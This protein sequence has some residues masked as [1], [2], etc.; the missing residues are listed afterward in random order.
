LYLPVYQL[1]QVERVVR[2]GLLN[3]SRHAQAQHINVGLEAAED[4]ITVR[5]EDDG[6]GF[7]PD[8]PAT[9]EGE[10][11]GL[12]IMRARAAR[13]GGRVEIDSAPGQGTRVIFT[14]PRQDG[15]AQT[16]LDELSTTLTTV[17]AGGQVI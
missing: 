1:E 17:G 4:E 11:F 12:S 10:H 7:D 9:Q 16:R 15:A 14:W 8:L 13:V 3:A 6:R 5:I 2:E